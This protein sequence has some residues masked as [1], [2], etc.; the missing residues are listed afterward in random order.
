[1][2]RRQMVWDTRLGNKLQQAQIDLLVLEAQ[3]GCEK[4]FTAIYRHYNIQLQHFAFRFC[5]DEQLA[6]DAVQETWIT[7]SKTLKSLEDPRGFRVWAFKTVRWRVV[8][9]VR[10]QKSTGGKPTEHLS[11]DIDGG[12]VSATA[13]LAT[14][15]QLK[16]HLDALPA[17]ERTCVSLFYLQELK[18]SEIAAVMDV[19]IGTIKSRLNRA[20]ER[21]RSKMSGDDNDET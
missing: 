13:S 4:A 3:Q 10:R 6:K 19:P 8:D 17:E 16:S 14:S 11:E 21:L 9:Q 7:L 2:T 12:E 20:R 18:L 5:G 1:M 15:S